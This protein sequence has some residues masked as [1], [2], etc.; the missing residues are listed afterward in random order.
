M[1]KA[2]TQANDLRVV[3]CFTFWHKKGFQWQGCHINGVLVRQC[4]TIGHFEVVSETG[5]VLSWIILY[6]GAPYD[7]VQETELKFIPKTVRKCNICYSN[8]LVWSITSIWSIHVAEGN[9]TPRGFN[10]YTCKTYCHNKTVFIL[11]AS[12]FTHLPHSLSC[13]LMPKYARNKFGRQHTV[14]HYMSCN[15]LLQ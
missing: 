12:H 7:V 14:S 6:Y 1:N 15:D 2:F 4:S 8:D 13:S 11:I 10:E 5:S 9:A 3:I